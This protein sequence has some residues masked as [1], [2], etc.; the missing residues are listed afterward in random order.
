MKVD[1]CRKALVHHWFL[2]MTGGEKVCEALCEILDAP[3]MFSILADPQ[4]LSPELRKSVLTTSFVQR[5]PGARKW[6]RYYT[7]MFPLAVELFDLSA[8]DLVISNDSNAVKGIITRPET[9]HICYCHS[10]MRYAWSMFQDYLKGSGPIRS[11]LTSLVMH[12]LRLWDYSAAARVDF[13]V[14]NSKA[15]RDRIRSYYRR[16]AKVI[17]P[18]C[19]IE[20]FQV[21]SQSQ[22]YYLSAGRL[23]DYKQVAMAVRAFGEN[24]M[25]L[26][27]AGDGPQK[28]YLKSIAKKN[29][30]IL[31]WVSDEELSTLYSGCKAL[32]FPGEEDFGIVP[33]EAQACGKP[34]IAYGRGGALETVVHGK[35]GLFFK[36][37]T[38][39]ALNET[40]AEFESTS[41][42]YDPLTIRQHAEHFG[43][44]RFQREFLEF[45]QECL[46]E[47]SNQFV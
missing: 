4:V 25:R 32:I 10:P 2:S 11:A 12:Y 9:C 21:S 33:V 43:K 37:P 46:D 45:V 47:H 16:D 30:E 7:W 28:N 17:H 34:V 24:G 31:G 36:N 18:P 15:V 1:D 26:I 13:F 6:Y 39:T 44:K 8:Y 41:D 35:T 29:I 19:D 42:R 22:D 23:V 14:G 40:I 3:D 5:I 38:P 27:V 20:K